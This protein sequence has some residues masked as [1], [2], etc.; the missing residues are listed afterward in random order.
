MPRSECDQ[1]ITTQLSAA[2]HRES[3][4]DRVWDRPRRE[5]GRTKL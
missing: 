2:G 5:E 3:L 4:P 1:E